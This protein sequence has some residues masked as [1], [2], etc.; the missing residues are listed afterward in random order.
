MLV[1][2][3]QQVNTYILEIQ[4]IGRSIPLDGKNAHC[5]K[6]TLMEIGLITIS[7]HQIKHYSPLRFTPTYF[8]KED[9]H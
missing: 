1:L 5:R 2:P 7:I 9:L 6:G 3:K 4:V 8:Q